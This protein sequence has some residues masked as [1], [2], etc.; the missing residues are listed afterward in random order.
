MLSGRPNWCPPSTSPTSSSTST[1]LQ[2]CLQK[3]TPIHT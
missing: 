2:A 3:R 1:L